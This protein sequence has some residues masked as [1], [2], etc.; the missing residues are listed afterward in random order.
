VC[1]DALGGQKAAFKLLEQELQ[2]V[3]NHPTTWVQTFKIPCQCLYNVQFTAVI[4]KMTDGKKQII[5]MMIQFV[6]FPW[7]CPMFELLGNELLGMIS[8]A[9]SFCTISFLEAVVFHH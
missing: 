4:S 5:K 3:V 9:T 8:N 2:A 7:S 1:T 6:L